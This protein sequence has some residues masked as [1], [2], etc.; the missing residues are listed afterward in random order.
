MDEKELNTKLRELIMEM[1][2]LPK[3]KQKQLDSLVEKTKQRHKDIKK[4]VDEIAMSLRSLRVCIKYLLFDLEAT[5][6]ERDGLKK[7]LN[8]QSTDDDKPSKTDSEM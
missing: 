5:R 6:R 7:M 3:D 1:V 2:D 4:N 8:D